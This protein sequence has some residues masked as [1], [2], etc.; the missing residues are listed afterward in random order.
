LRVC[1]CV[2]S[3]VSSQNRRIVIEVEY[4]DVQAAYSQA[5]Y[6]SASLSIIKYRV[7]E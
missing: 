5:D 6:E 4:D 1:T 2:A 3:S 7:S